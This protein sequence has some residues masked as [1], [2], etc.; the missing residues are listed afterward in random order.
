MTKLLSLLDQRGL[1]FAR[2][3]RLGDP[4][5]GARGRANARLQGGLYG[6]EVAAS[7]A[8][9]RSAAPEPEAVFV[10]C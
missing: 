7:M 4:W 2:A 3:D 5:E 9:Q 6:S 10:S 1:F 8:S